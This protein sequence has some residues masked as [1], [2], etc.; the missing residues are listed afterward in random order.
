MSDDDD[1]TRPSVSDPLVK[2]SERTLLER[3]EA[4]QQAQVVIEAKRAGAASFRAKLV[5]LFGGVLTAAIVAAFV[6]VWNAQ[7]TNALQGA[8]II[9]IERRAHEHDPPPPGHEEHDAARVLLD[10]RVDGVERATK[11]I[12]DR[13]DR[14]DRDAV[15]RHRQIL[16]E[17]R[18]MRRAP[19]TWGG[20]GG[21]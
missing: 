7:T 17:I 20:G 18:R 4:A 21:E 1:D 10:R 9:E 13:L 11:A 19:R 14:S 16:E 12:N 2:M 3:I 8:A 15:E 5:T 6:W